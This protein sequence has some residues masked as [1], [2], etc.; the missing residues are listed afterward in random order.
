MLQRRPKDI[1]VD[2]YAPL[3]LLVIVNLAVTVKRGLTTCLH[4][5]R[6]RKIKVLILHSY[7]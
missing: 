1:Y 4:M 5:P 7:S 3:V 2:V 6:L